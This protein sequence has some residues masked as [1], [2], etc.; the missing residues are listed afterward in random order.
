MTR[1]E[2]LKAVMMRMDGRTYEEIAQRLHYGYATVYGELQQ[3]V[4]KKNVIRHSLDDVV[5]PEIRDYITK[6]DLTIKTLY[7]RAFDTEKSPPNTF[8]KQ[9]YGQ[10]EMSYYVK[11]NLA[12]LI[13][14]PHSVLFRRDEK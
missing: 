7:M 11:R 6:H 3:L 13:D 2:I 10:Q 14:M 8:Y 4:S 12:G 1:G 9:L 5:Y